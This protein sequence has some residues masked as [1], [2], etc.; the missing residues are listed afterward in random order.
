MMARV[1]LLIGFVSCT[2]AMGS[3]GFSKQALAAPEGSYLG[4]TPPGA[5]PKVFAPGIVSTDGWETG[6]FFA[7]NMTEFYLNRYDKDT[8]VSLVVFRQKPDKRW[9]EERLMQRIGRP[10]ISPDGKVMHLGEKYMERIGDSWSEVKSLG[11]AFEDLE[12]MR[13]S[14]SLAGTYVFDEIGLPEGDGVLRYSRLVDGKRE[15]PQ[16][17]GEQINTG[18]YTAHPFIAPDEADT[19][20]AEQLLAQHSLRGMSSRRTNEVILVVL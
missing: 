17:F 15:T 14:A 1:H 11:A 6:P 19:D 5:T 8:G 9:Y 18:K 16:E 13:L 10:I 20:S 4:Q 3:L 2:L 7:P 12:I